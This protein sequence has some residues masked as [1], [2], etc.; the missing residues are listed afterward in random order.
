M[1]A[2]E[3]VSLCTLWVTQGL[4]QFASLCNPDET[5]RL[6]G[7]DEVGQVLLANTWLLPWFAVIA[8]YPVLVPNTVRRT[9]CIVGVTAALPILA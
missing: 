9:V 6:L 1:P 5:V 4:N 8:G 7:N 3:W 2:A